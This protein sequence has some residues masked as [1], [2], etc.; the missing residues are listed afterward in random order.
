MIF[1][2]IGTNLDSKYGNKLSNLNVIIK[3]LQLEKIDILNTSSI[4]ETPSYPDK[5]KPKFLNIVI[6]I[7]FDLDLN[8][9]FKKI[10]LIE[11]KMGR[12]RTSKNEPRICDIDVIDFNQ[13]VIDSESIILPHPRAHK[14]NFVL[15]PLQEIN[16]QWTHPKSNKKINLLIDNLNEN[17]SNEITRLKERVIFNK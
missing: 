14:R 6:Q 3:F 5:Q 1:L 2:G 4:Y 11:K 12:K 7:K 10:L 17:E 9:L 8:K 16:P 13:V 15:Y